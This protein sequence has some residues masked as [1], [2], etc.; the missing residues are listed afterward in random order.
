V[1]AFRLAQLAR[2]EDRDPS[3]DFVDARL[4]SRGIRDMIVSVMFGNSDAQR[5]YER[6]GVRPAETVPYSFG[7]D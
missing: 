4:A 3:A 6:R 2:A 5:L 7:S 1:F